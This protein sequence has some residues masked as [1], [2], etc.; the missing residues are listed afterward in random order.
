MAVETDGKCRLA[1]LGRMT[2]A[3]G[4]IR[5]L[6]R[7]TRVGLAV[8]VCS[9][10]AAC[11]TTTAPSSSNGTPIS[12]GV[13]T[14]ALGYGYGF[15]WILPINNTTNW[16]AYEE[17]IEAGM[18]L[19]LYFAGGP[20]TTGMNYKLSLAYPPVYSNG[21]RTV[22]ITMKRGFK[23]SDGTPVTTADVR[24]FFELEAAAVRIHNYGPYL[25]GEMP[26]DIK[27]VTYNG[28]YEFTIQLKRSYN[29]VYFTGNQLSWIWPIPQ[30]AWDKTCLTCK[31]GNDAATPAGADSVIRFLYAQS[32]ELSTYATNPLWK[33]VDGPWVISS[34]DPVTYHVMFTANSAYKGPD[35]PHLREYGIYSFASD[36]AEL[37]AV[38]SGTI[39]FGYLPISDV[40]SAKT[41]EAEGYTV[42]TWPAF[43]NEVIEFGYTNKTYGPLVRQ[44]YIRQALQH[45]VDESLYISTTL[46]GYGVPD[47]GIA[48]DEPGPYTSPALR[49]DPYP[50]SLSAA[51]AL[52]R[53]HGWVKNAN[54][55]DVCEHPGLGQNQCGPGIVR[56][57][58]LT[59]RFMYSTGSQY[60]EA[61]VEAFATAASKAGIALP[62][63]PQTEGTMVSIAG[64]CPPGP[65]NWGLAGYSGYMWDFGWYALVPT[66]DQQFSKGNYWAGG[67]YSP[68]AQKLIDNADTKPG[69]APLYEAENYLSEQVASLWWPLPDQYVALVKEDLRGWSPLNPYVNWEP[70]RWYFVK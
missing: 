34:Y 54:G 21:D 36:T 25:P 60:F 9:V 50:Y 53:S 18:W 20:G 35:K 26:D 43:A 41:Y 30:H 37:D 46:H 59:L 58:T 19:P 38:R 12:G 45:L 51:E 39:T 29:P 4:K 48:P 32:S 7:Y 24:F 11:T 62:L 42:K 65:C 14:Y 27:S 16:E 6:H 15:Q 55:V 2:S 66:G 56:G 5:S 52:L 8:F 44:L 22:R 49:R 10:L 33:V 1:A 17:N 67:Y 70:E 40:A 68:T 28:P 23:W 3:M 61:Q 69:L 47:Y 13:A 63:D 64:V 57:K 31:V